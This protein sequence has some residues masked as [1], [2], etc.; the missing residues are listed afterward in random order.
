VGGGIVSMN[1]CNGIVF[2]HSVFQDTESVVQ[3]KLKGIIH[4]SSVVFARKENF[5]RQIIR[6]NGTLHLADVGANPIFFQLSS[7]LKNNSLKDVAL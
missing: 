1:W 4:Y 5:E 7:V 6:E 2:Q 3:E